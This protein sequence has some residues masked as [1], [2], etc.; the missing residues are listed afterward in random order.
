MSSVTDDMEIQSALPLLV[1]VM[2][3]L[4]RDFFVYLSSPSVLIPSYQNRQP[5]HMPFAQRLTCNAGEN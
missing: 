2:V 3:N 1:F 5:L 4:T